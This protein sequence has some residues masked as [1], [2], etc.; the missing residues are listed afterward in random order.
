MKFNYNL[1]YFS[2]GDLSFY[3]SPFQATGNRS[4]SS[5]D[6][7]SPESYFDVFR[8]TDI[9]P[10]TPRN[11]LDTRSFESPNVSQYD[12]T[13]VFERPFDNFQLNV[14]APD[15]VPFFES[16]ISSLNI[17]TRH[18]RPIVGRKILG[19]QAKAEPIKDVKENVWQAIETQ[20]NYELFPSET[21][22]Y[23]FRTP[24]K[25]NSYSIQTN[26]SPQNTNIYN[27][28]PSY[29]SETPKFKPFIP[30]STASSSK[31]DFGSKM[32][33]FCRKNGETPMVYMTH[34]VKEKVGNRHIVTCPILRSHE[35]KT[36]GASG[37][38]AHTL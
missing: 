28:R 8:H 31:E 32:C 27:R 24:V 3:T 17:Q 14:Q 1:S 5:T 38:N 11:I 7:F 30:V 25:T 16:P 36:C 4:S 29:S 18:Q 12:V 2:D 15:F 23:E 21:K 37:D 6:S 35:C 19:S 10:E 20:K 34:C 22:G 26:I 9:R 33:T 13:N